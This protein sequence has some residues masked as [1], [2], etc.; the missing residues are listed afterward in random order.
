MTQ[1]VNDMDDHHLLLD[2]R[3]RL[4]RV[5]EKISGFGRIIA[6]IWGLFVAVLLQA[7]GFLYGYAQLEQTVTS[8][9]LSEIRQNNLTAL[10]VLADHGTEFA[11]VQTELTRLRSVDDG[12][13]Q[14][15]LN[16]ATK[17]DGQT[18]DRFTGAEGR[19]MRSHNR[20]QMD[21]LEARIVRIEDRI[22]KQ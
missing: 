12:I 16:M 7:G 8:L 2:E 9:N 15:M 14:S 18:K 11:N 6:A 22:F 17:I 19:E 10:T 4:I 21:R 5:E 3:E 20:Q 1:E 13:N